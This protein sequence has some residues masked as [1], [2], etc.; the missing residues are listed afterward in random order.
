MLIMKQRKSDRL[1]PEEPK[2]QPDPVQA[3]HEQFLQAFESEISYDRYSC[4]FTHNR[5][6]VHYVI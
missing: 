5:N 4:L 3:D 1:I 6:C 2:Q